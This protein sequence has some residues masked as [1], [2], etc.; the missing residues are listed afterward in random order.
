MPKTIFSPAVRVSTEWL[1]GSQNLV[2][3]G[4]DEDWHYPPLTSDSLQLTGEGGMDSVLVTVGTAQT[5]TGPKVWSNSN[6]FTGSLVANGQTDE[7][8]NVPATSFDRNLFLSNNPNGVVTN[9]VLLDYFG[10][11]DGGEI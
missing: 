9:Q 5:V 10:V 8:E 1:N 3:D 7:W 4:A 2:F 6:T 11:I